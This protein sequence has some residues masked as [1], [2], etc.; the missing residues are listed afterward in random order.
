MYHI[1]IDRTMSSFVKFVLSSIEEIVLLENRMDNVTE[2]IHRKK[3]VVG[4]FGVFEVGQYSFTSGEV[5]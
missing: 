5:G 2:E 3:W 4:V 1:T